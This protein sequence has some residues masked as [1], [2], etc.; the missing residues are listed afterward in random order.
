M[1]AFVLQ[2][3]DS[4][5]VVCS[6][7]R[8]CLA[9]GE[10]RVRIHAAALNRRDDWIRQGAYPGLKAPIV[11][12]SDGCG[13]VEQVRDAD[14]SWI[15]RRVVINP[16]I[17]WGEDERVQGPDYT[18]LGMPRDGTLAEYLCVPVENLV[19]APEHLDD[20]QAAALPLAGLTAWRALVTRAELVAG[21]RVLVTGIGG[22]VSLVGA[23]LALAMG[24]RVWVSS[25]STTKIERARQLGVEGGVNYGDPEWARELR[26]QCPEGFDVIL[27]G[28][29]G[30]GFGSLARMLAPAGRLVFYGGTR[31]RWPRL[32]PQ[33]VFFRQVS[34]LAT[35]MGSP[36]EFSAMVAFVSRVRLVPVVDRVFSL[37][38]SI[39][40]LEHLDAPE[41][42][43]KVVVEMNPA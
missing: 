27:D 28:A 22:G 40:S 1:R 38:D 5:P 39:L 14:P 3:L 24:A 41:R 13:V 17:D 31:G 32:L 19:E 2:T 11:L 7:P 21:E 42:F 20:N 10:A 6:V 8:P 16:S 15:G 25:G 26:A 23:Q 43:G 9:P 12:G 30:E 35:S 4:P 37:E 36:T 29:G 34:I 33:H 18:I